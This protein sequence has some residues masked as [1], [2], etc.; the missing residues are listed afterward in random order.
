MV[1][2]GEHWTYFLDVPGL[3]CSRRQLVPRGVEWLFGTL[4]FLGFWDKKLGV[5]GALG[6]VIAFVGTVTHDLEHSLKLAF[7]HREVTVDD[8]FL[9]A[10]REGRPRVDA[11]LLCNR[12]VVHH[13]RAANDDLE[14]AVLGLPLPKYCFQGFG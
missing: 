2:R 5:L 4:L 7:N 14:H 8:R 10:A 3:R 9:I 6:S 12:C 1:G 13:R 11:H